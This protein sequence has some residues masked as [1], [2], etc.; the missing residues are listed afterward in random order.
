M[1]RVAAAVLLLALFLT[2]CATESTW[3]GQYDLGLRYLSEGNYEQAILA[4]T[5]AIEID[6]KQPETYLSLADAYMAQGDTE[7]AWAVLE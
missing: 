3:Q 4:F 7:S 5:A 1:K 6:P 2:A